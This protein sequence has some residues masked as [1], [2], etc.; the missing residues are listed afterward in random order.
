[1]HHIYRF[2]LIF[3]ALQ[4]QPCFASSWETNICVRNTTASSHQ[5]T[6][7]DI[8]NYDWDGN[9]RPDHNFNNLSIAAGETICRRAECNVAAVLPEPFQTFTF[10]VDDTPTRM[11]LRNTV[12]IETGN[13]GTIYDQARWGAFT[14]KEAPLTLHGERT[15]WFAPSNWILGYPCN[16]KVRCSFFEIR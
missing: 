16:D 2:G 8:S 10:I 13:N 11:G 9:S 7:A 6:V 4:S 14:N 12:R 15:L 5:I 3:I 1:M